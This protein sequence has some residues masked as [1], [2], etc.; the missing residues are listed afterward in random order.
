MYIVVYAIFRY[1]NININ[2]SNKLILF[3][4]ISTLLNGVRQ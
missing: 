3:K 1:A 4:F 2:E